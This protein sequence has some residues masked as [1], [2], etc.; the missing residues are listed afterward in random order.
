MSHVRTNFADI[1]VR[2]IR[3]YTADELETMTSEQFDA[4]PIAD[5][6]SIYNGHRDAYNRLTHKTTDDT[7]T[8]TEDS[9]TDSQKF[10]DEFERRLD[11]ALARAFPT[12]EL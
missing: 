7:T 9:R 4:L 6:I 2:N 10:C 5:Q 8:H 1:F 12:A 3:E 11:E